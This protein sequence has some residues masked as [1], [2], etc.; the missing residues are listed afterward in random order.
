MTFVY[1]NMVRL[2]YTRGQSYGARHASETICAIGILPGWE[3]VRT[4]LEYKS[5]LEFN[6]YGVPGTPNGLCFAL[7][8]QLV[9]TIYGFALSHTYDSSSERVYRA[10]RWCTRYIAPRRSRDKSEI[11]GW[12]LFPLSLT[13]IGYIAFDTSKRSL[14]RHLI[15][16]LRRFK[17]VIYRCG[18]FAVKRIGRM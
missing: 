12:P 5:E 11:Y 3:S 13:S 9:Y 18:T 14:S 1:R 4:W 16:S 17:D 2:L 6:E 10:R 7:V 15:A 8:P